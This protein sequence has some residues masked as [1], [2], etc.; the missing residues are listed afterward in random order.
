METKQQQAI[1]T[2]Q[3]SYNCAQSVLSVFAQELGV[4]KDNALKLATP[5][6]AG[7]MYMQETC[8]AVT[9]ALMAIGLKYGKGENGTLEDKER[10]YDMGRY[11]VAEFSKCHGSTSC[12][13]L[14]KEVNLSTPDGMKYAMDNQLFHTHCAN[15]VKD[16]V[17]IT[18]RIIMK[19]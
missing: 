5:F 14:L 19:K 2:F 10:A 3:N 12:L 16:A 7:M 8:G 6:G 17:A 4:S 18:E 11:F 1:E 15:Y 9:G 13:K